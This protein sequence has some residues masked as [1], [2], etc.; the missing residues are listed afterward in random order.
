MNEDKRKR[1]LWGSAAAVL[2]WSGW[3][4][5]KGDD[6]AL[7]E[8]A[9]RNPRPAAAQPA[10]TGSPAVQTS[11]PATEPGAAAATATAA[12]TP[13]ERLS[14]KAER[15]AF[16]ARSFVDAPPPPRVQAA[17][18]PAPVVAA[19]AAPVAPPPPALPYRYVGMLESLPSDKPKV[20]LSVG[21]KLIVAAPGDA[22]DGGFR[23]EAIRA[24]E[25]VFLHVQQG[26][27]VRLPLSGAPS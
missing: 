20:F 1:L 5:W 13:G 16:G 6:A 10:A 11:T 26:V 15:D 22:L 9:P 2:A 25:L 24:T 4:V 19:P 12:A 3:I 7:V 21:D 27:T 18:P 8:V 23:L 14:A 17:P